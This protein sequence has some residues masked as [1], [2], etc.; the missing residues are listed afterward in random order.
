MDCRCLFGV[1]MEWRFPARS[2]SEESTETPTKPRE[3]NRSLT[4]QVGTVAE[5]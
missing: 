2:V 1:L 5:D 3:R 4:Q